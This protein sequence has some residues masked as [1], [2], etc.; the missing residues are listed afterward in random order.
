MD[1]YKALVIQQK[2]YLSFT[3]TPA[4][5]PPFSSTAA[6]EL[7]RNVKHNQ[8]TDLQMIYYLSYTGQV[9]Q[10]LGQKT[11]VFQTIPINFKFHLVN[12][13]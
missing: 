11:N 2:Q 1:F 8:P 6:S 13:K 10:C 4:T 12:S 9:Q 5:L 3:G 7:Q